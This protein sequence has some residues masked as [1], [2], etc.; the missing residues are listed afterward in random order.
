MRSQFSCLYPF[1]F[2]ATLLLTAACDRP[3]DQ[4]AV[5]QTENKVEEELADFRNWV[6]AKTAKADST[7]DDKWPEVKEEFKQR[8]ARLDARLDSL[9]ATS[10]EEY[11]ELRRK[12]NNWEASSQQRAEMPLHGE[13]L[14]RFKTELLGSPTAL[15]SIWAPDRVHDTYATFLQNVRKNRSGWTAA[16][17]D[18]VDE[19]YQQMSHKKDAVE[20][21][22]S[23]GDKLKIKALQAEY[24]TLETGH[25]AKG[26]FKA[27]K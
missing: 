27:V 18:Y 17:W 5:T 26:L 24:L 13:T 2:C 6:A 19:I 12:F 7:A 15:D 4:T 16:D 11:K 9:S 20:R 14:R 8:S 10:K 1:L 3:S 22:I 21:N 23:P 25:D